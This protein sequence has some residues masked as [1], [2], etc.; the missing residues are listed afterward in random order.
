MHFFRNSQSA[1]LILIPYFSWFRPSPFPTPCQIQGADVKD[2]C[3]EER[4]I[5]FFNARNQ[6]NDTQHVIIVQILRSKTSLSTGDLKAST[7]PSSSLFWKMAEA[8]SF[9]EKEKIRLHLCHA[10][11]NAPPPP[12]C[13]AG[14]FWMCEEFQRQLRIEAKSNLRTKRLCFSSPPEESIQEGW[15][16]PFKMPA[17]N[18]WYGDYKGGVLDIVGGKIHL[19]LWSRERS[20]STDH[21]EFLYSSLVEN[22]FNVYK[23]QNYLPSRWAKQYKTRAMNW[24]NMTAGETSSLPLKLSSGARCSVAPGP[25]SR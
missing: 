3:H 1:I 12:G 22:V 4:Q 6:V 17:A 14:T 5:C 13:D 15:W 8:G 19:S 20:T 18:S 21:K 2:D 24:R 23:H 25:N 16:S 9:S 7:V 11:T 10:R